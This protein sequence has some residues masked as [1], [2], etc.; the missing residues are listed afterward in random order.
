MGVHVG[1]LL[2]ADS[3]KLGRWSVRL[4]QNVYNFVKI[5]QLVKRLKLGTRR[6]MQRCYGDITDLI[7]Y[8]MKESRLKP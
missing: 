1:M 7:R 8:I 4:W 6:H 3:C 2:V 5:G